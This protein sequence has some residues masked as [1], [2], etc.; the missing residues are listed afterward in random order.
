MNEVQKKRIMEVKKQLQSEV[1]TLN[2][3]DINQDDRDISKAINTAQAKIIIAI[4]SIDYCLS[5]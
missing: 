2:N 1:K 3:I 5:I 4:E